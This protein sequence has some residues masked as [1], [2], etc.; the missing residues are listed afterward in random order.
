MFLLLEL[1]STYIL[2]ETFFDHNFFRPKFFKSMPLFV[3]D[4]FKSIGQYKSFYFSIILLVNKRFPAILLSNTRFHAI[5]L[6]NTRFP[7]ISL[8]NTRFSC[9]SI[10]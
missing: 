9:N 8:V 7:A 10:G 3:L 1:G 2:V 4:N 5:L 6:G